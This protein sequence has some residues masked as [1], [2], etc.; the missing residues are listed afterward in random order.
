MIR[1][2]SSLLLPFALN[3]FDLA[4]FMG[5]KHR[6]CFLLGRRT[7]ESP[8]SDAEEALL[9]DNDKTEMERVKKT[10]LSALGTDIQSLCPEIERNGRNKFLLPLRPTDENWRWFQIESGICQ[11]TNRVSLKAA[12]ARTGYFEI[13]QYSII[14]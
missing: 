9:I 2:M 6:S 3:A 7:A 11:L 13:A 14:L 12:V 5:P 10:A 8:P 4:D 1:Y